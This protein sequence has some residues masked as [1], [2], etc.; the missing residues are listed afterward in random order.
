MAELEE[1]NKKEE[2]AEE[3]GAEEEK[4]TEKILNV[5]GEPALIRELY[6]EVKKQELDAGDLKVK[7][8]TSEFFTAILEFGEPVTKFVN[9]THT[10]LQK[11]KDKEKKPTLTLKDPFGKEKGALS[12]TQSKEDIQKLVLA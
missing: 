11:Y 9:V 10:L 12:V 3:D 7:G 6:G 1:E 8:P 4:E 2:G 5:F